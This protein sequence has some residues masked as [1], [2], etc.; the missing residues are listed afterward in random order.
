MKKFTKPLAFL[1]KLT[2]SALLISYLINNF[3]VGQ[4][5]R[6]IRPLSIWII[7]LLML[8]F[9][10]QLLVSSFRY[11]KILHIMGL[12]IAYKSTLTSVFIGYFFSQTMI[13]F[14][15]GD[16]MRIFYTSRSGGKISQIT[17]A[18]VLD[19]L[20]GF[21][22]QIL[23]LG[24]ILPF[25][26]PLLPNKIMQTWIIIIVASSFTLAL[27]TIAFGTKKNLLN[28]SEILNM[29]SNYSKRI[30]DR[31]YTG[32]G[33]F[34]FIGLSLV[35]ALMN[36]FAY[37]LIGKALNIQLTLTDILILTPPVFFLSMLPI[38]ISG[39]GVREAATVMMLGL[40]GIS[41]H[42]ALS[43]SIVFGL[44]L[45]LISL[46]GGILWLISPKQIKKEEFA[47]S[48]RL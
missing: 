45:L 48:Q 44:S 17:K 1:A 27:A 4:V 19:R 46:P 29:I 21:A 40:A 15:G 38:S 47:K 20:S 33:M 34:I 12:F 35:I 18:V 9:L 5:L 30:L 13:S 36:C 7:A 25:L 6:D 32:K 39:W 2:I 37:Y 3:E 43:I 16:A 41:S 24:L 8:T 31:L 11:H 42:D 23:Q 28:R 14:V 26:L 22:G 10:T